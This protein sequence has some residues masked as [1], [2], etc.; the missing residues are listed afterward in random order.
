MFQISSGVFFDA[1]KI[2]AGVVVRAGDQ[3]YIQQFILLWE[4]YFNCVARLEKESVK[5]ICAKLN[6]NKNHSKIALEVA[7]YL[8]EINRN[9]SQNTANG[10][11]DFFE[12]CS[13]YR[14]CWIHVCDSCAENN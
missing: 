9:V 8:V 13:K 7:P 5:K 6:F 4:F 12:K 11:C 2:E 14:T 3:D 10:F 1:D